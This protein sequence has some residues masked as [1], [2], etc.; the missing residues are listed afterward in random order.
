VFDEITVPFFVHVFVITKLEDDMNFLSAQSFVTYFD[1]V[2][3][4]GNWNEMCVVML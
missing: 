4:L 1:D 2:C 3:L